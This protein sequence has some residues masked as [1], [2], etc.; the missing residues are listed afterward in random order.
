M[1]HSFV[2]QN[3]ENVNIQKYQQVRGHVYRINKYCSTW[4]YISRYTN[5]KDYATGGNDYGGEYY[6]IIDILVPTYT[7][8]LIIG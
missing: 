2:I 1:L 6:D 8:A 5:R 7:A 3:Q 4:S